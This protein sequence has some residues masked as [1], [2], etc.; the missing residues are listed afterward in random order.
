[1]EQDASER[2]VVSSFEGEDLRADPDAFYALEYKPRLKAMIDHVIATEAPV[3]E[4]ILARRIARHH[5]FKRAGHR[6]RDIIIRLARRRCETTKE[7][8]GIFYWPNDQELRRRVPARHLGRD[9]EMRNVDYICAEELRAINNLCGTDDQAKE[10]AR[11]LGIARVTEGT[12][13]RIK[14][15]SEGD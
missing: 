10:L 4:D 2:Y 8:V 5:G 3:H 7:K 6:V 1:M 9:D 13:K 14:E 15:A 12:E 11:E